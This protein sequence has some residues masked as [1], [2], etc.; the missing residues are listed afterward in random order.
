MKFTTTGLYLEDD[1]VP[2]LAAKW[3]GKTA[4]E[5]FESD[6]FFR[7]I[8]TCPFEKFFR[9][10]HLLPLTGQDFTGKVT[11]NCASIIKSAGVYG[12]AEAT[13]I[14]KFKEIYG[15]RELSVG[16]SNLYSQ[17]PTGLLTITF[18]E[19]GSIIPEKS[20]ATIDN[21]PLSEAL[22]DSIIGSNGVSPAAR[23]S[24]AERLSQI[25]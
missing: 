14:D 22:L 3:K 8:V 15:D 10:T 7:D 24:L 12:D 25:L 17:S 21:K 11:E 16:F 23:R 9:L 6:E 19:D 13:A 20:G 4:E 5:L 1:V 18:T 2:W